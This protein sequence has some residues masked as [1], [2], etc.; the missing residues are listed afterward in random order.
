MEKRIVLNMEETENNRR[1]SE[2][3]FFR[4]PNGDIL[5]AYSRYNSQLKDDEDPCDIALMRSSDEGETWS[6]PKIIVE[7]DAFG[8]KNIMCASYLSLNDGR[9]CI[10]F[11]V[12][13]NDGSSTIGRAI[14]ED[15][16]SFKPERCI[17]NMPKAFYV[18]ENDRFIRLSDGRVATVA[19][20]VETG[21]LM[22][23]TVVAIVSDD[24]GKEFHLA[25]ACCSLP[26]GGM[27]KHGLEEPILVELS[28]NLIWVLARS[29]YSYQYQAFSV[30]GLKSFTPVE[31]SVFS[32]QLSPISVK[33]LKDNSLIA[34]YNPMPSFDGRQE[35]LGDM[36]VEEWWSGRTPFVLRRSIDNG[37][38]WGKLYIIENE[39]KSDFAYPALF[40]TEDDGILCAYWCKNSENF[41]SMRIMKFD[42]I[43]GIK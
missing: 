2:G 25:G 21:Y 14:S 16:V 38:T 31:P 41:F 12:N 19:S 27:Q 32:S 29:S 34:A 11:L 39:K 43:P 22:N 30:D 4:A 10:Y 33:R 23:Q 18:I 1:N 37:K 6:E 36:M 5:Y 28:S 9:M 15:G 35:L 17:C 3:C 26:F 7:A 8:V 13:E 20:K 24:D 42:E 40:E